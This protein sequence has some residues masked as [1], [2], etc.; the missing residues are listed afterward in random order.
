MV[1]FKSLEEIEI[2]K[3]SGQIIAKVL[4]KLKEFVTPGISTFEL[5]AIA[6]E[7]IR[8]YGAIPSFLNYGTPPF[9]GSICTSINDEVVHG[10]PSKKRILVEGDIVSIDVGAYIDGFHADAARTFAVGKIAE[11]IKKLIEV[12][13]ECFWKGME[14]LKPGNRISD[15][16]SAIEQH[17]LLHKYGIVKELTGHGIGRSLHED[18]DVPNYRTKAQGIRISEGLA[19]AIEPMINIG[20]SGVVIGDDNWTI[21]TADRKVSAHYENTVAVTAKGNVITTILQ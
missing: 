4:D 1:L 11:D 10:I 2:M 16:S 9:P 20:K 15:V 6:D 3:R 14:Q 19:V 13:E 12:T 17:A 7:T 8:K 5:N 18:P 21:S